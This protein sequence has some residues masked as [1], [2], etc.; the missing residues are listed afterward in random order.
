MDLDTGNGVTK[1][2]V[3]ILSDQNKVYEVEINATT[4]KVMK[5][6]QEND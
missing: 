2:E 1:Y 5:V 6:E 4:G 3:I